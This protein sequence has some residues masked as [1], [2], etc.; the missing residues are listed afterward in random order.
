[1]SRLSQI[2]A[3]LPTAWNSYQSAVRHSVPGLPFDRF[4]RSLGVRLLKK[5]YRKGARLLLRPV[6]LERYLEFPFALNSLPPGA[7]RCLDVSSPNLFSYYVAAKGLC[8]SILM[9]NPDRVDIEDTGETV[10]SLGLCRIQCQCKGIET[11]GPEDEPFDC[12]WCISVIEHIA[13][14]NVDDV[15]AMQ[16]MYNALRPGGRLI[17]T[18]VVDRKAWVEYRDHDAYGLQSSTSASTYFFQRWYDLSALQAR[19]W[20]PLGRQPS[21]ILWYGEKAA[22]VYD[23]FVARWRSPNWV[24]SLESGRIVAEAYR[25]YDSFEEMP[26]KGTVCFLIDKPL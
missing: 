18:T 8:E 24:V 15:K 16:V 2:S 5:G 4:G 23:D 11:L 19:L 20:S 13:G 22:G 21:T 7:K 3:A 9:I 6:I 26:G 25:Q 14:E 10:R 12:I 1:M 17:V